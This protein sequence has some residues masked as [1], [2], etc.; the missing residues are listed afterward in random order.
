MT[1]VTTKEEG[2]EKTQVASTGT[3]EGLIEDLQA[4]AEAEK[5]AE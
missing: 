5:A 1:Y 2:E 3:L 4:L